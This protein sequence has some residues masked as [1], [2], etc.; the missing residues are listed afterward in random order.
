MHGRT[1]QNKIK[2]YEVH[3]AVVQLSLK[4]KVDKLKKKNFIKLLLMLILEFFMTFL[5]YLIIKM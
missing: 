2:T 5:F 1:L 3:E 4:Q